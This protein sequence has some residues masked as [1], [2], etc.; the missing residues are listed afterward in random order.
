MAFT[1][2]NA[3]SLGAKGGKATVAKH[4]RAHMATIAKL[5]FAA[6]AAKHPGGR[7]GLLRELQRK[8]WQVMDPF[9]QNGAWTP[10]ERNET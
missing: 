5:G 4:G 8:G 9:P 7:E 3:S 6:R 2:E 1:E 10:R